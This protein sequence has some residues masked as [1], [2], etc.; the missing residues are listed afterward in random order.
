MQKLKNI[1]AILLLAVF[2]FPVVESEIHNF[3]HINDLHFSS[4]L[5]HFSAEKHPCNLCDFTFGYTGA[6]SFNQHD[7]VFSDLC[8][9]NYFFLNNNLLP[10]LNYFNSLRA[11]PTSI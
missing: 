4:S 8:T 10:P 7:F 2:L 9:L 5:D 6:I 3:S 1:I 11:P